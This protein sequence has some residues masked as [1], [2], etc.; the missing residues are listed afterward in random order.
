MGRSPGMERAN[1]PKQIWIDPAIV[2]GALSRPLASFV[3]DWKYLIR[4]RDAFAP[5]ARSGRLRFGRVCRDALSNSGI[6]TPPC[7]PC[8]AMLACRYVVLHASPHANRQA[9]SS[10]SRGRDDMPVDPS[11]GCPQ[12]GP[13]SACG[14]GDKRRRAPRA[15]ARDDPAESPGSHACPPRISLTSLFRQNRCWDSRRPCL[16]DR[17]PQCIAAIR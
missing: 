14:D 16:H 9:R 15:R 10:R 13:C 6:P 8:A 17:W 4:V 12:T 1:A 7:N 3:H 2:F 5:L 11:R